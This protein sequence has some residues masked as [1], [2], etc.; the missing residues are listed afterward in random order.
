MWRSP[1]RRIPEPSRRGSSSQGTRQAGINRVSLGAQSF[2]AARALRQLGRIH[3]AEDTHRAVEELRAAKLDNFNLDL[4]YALPQ[5]SAGR[6]RWRM[7]ASPA[8]VR[9]SAHLLLPT[10]PRARYGI[11]L[12]R[13]PPLPD[14]DTAWGMQIAGQSGYWRRRTTRNTK[15]RPTLAKARD[16][17]TTSTTGCSEIT[18]ASGP[19]RMAS[20][21]SRGRSAY[22]APPSPNSRANIRSRFAA[23]ARAAMPGRARVLSSRRQTCP[24]SSC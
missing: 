4:M 16:A 23:R 6:R 11:S 22:C 21:V 3:S 7:S 24:S 18:W 13:P 2:V 14:D 1:W 17:G 15:S 12:A 5:Q 20:S 8:R 19:G 10:D 9:A